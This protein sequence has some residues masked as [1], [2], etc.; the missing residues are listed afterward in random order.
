MPDVRHGHCCHEDMPQHQHEAM[1]WTGVQLPLPCY[2][3]T[4][5]PCLIS[6]DIEVLVFH[7]KDVLMCRNVT[8]GWIKLKADQWKQ[9]QG[10]QKFQ[11]GNDRRVP[12][13]P[14]F[15]FNNIIPIPVNMCWR[16]SIG[17]LIVVLMNIS[18]VQSPAWPA[19][20]SRVSRHRMQ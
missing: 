18:R 20:V 17:Y 6:E 19:E 11:C 8:S 1:L 3:V 14:I 15:I 4:Y 10:R 7:I 9:Q 13:Q 16:R 5:L 12:H 2:L